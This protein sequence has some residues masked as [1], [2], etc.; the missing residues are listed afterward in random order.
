MATHSNILCV[1]VCVYLLFNWRDN[2]FIE[3]CCFQSNINMKQPS[4]QFSCS[5][6]SDS[7]RPYR[8]LQARLPCPLTTAGACSNSC[9]LSRWCHP[10]ISSSI[11]LF[12]SCLQSFPSSGSFPMSQ[13]FVSGDQSTGSSAS[14]SVLPMNLQD[15]FPLRLN[16][17]ISWQSKGVKSLLEHHS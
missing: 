14:T 13:F 1:C 11:V 7:S 2:C 15:W 6:V 12:S 9:P 5:V 3:F 17:L 16:G 10:T 8:L 4:V